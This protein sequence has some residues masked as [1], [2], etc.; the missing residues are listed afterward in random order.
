[1]E[2]QSHHRGIDVWVGRF[3]VGQELLVD[4]LEPLGASEHQVGS[5]Q[6]IEPRT[7]VRVAAADHRLELDRI[8]L[9]SADPEHRVI[10]TFAI[11]GDRRIA[12]PIHQLLAIHL[13]LELLD[14]LVGGQGELVVAIASQQGVWVFEM[15]LVK[16]QACDR[17]LGQ[18]LDRLH[19]LLR[20][21]RQWQRGGP[22]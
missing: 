17:I 21:G 13:A 7:L 15:F 18:F 8:G 5:D 19:V 6:R 2:P 4:E 1:M 12:D 11:W 9:G 3:A 20:I 16:L 22:D 14:I 10:E